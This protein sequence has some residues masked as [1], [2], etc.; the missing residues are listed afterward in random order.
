MSEP[1]CINLQERFGKRYRVS[2]EAN[3]AS[4]HQ[5]PK[6]DWP[7]LMELRCRYGRVYPKGGEILQA[8]TD[9]PRIGAQL[10][11][12]PCVLTTRGDA[13]IVVTVPVDHAPAV[14]AL[15]RPYRRRQLSDAQ[16]ERLRVLSAAHGFQRGGRQHNV[17]SDFPTLES[18]IG[19]PD[20]S[21]AVPRTEEGADAV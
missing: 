19:A 15:L 21:E 17:Q 12:L 14:V 13:E 5:W 18:T 11:A 6:E 2:L 9:R 7:W 3:G 1:T 16:R 20:G 10:R 4:K 8:T